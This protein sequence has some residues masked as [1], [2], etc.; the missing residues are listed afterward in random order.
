MALSKDDKDELFYIRRSDLYAEIGKYENSISDLGQAL[1]LKPNDPM[2]LY[3][4]GLSYYYS[5]K[6]KHAIRDFK[7]SLENHPHESYEPDLHYH[8]GIAFA[9]LEN[10]EEAIDPLSRVNILIL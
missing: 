8:I 5:K 3:K 9:N 2:I 6:Y 7:E 10:F 1:E 4:R